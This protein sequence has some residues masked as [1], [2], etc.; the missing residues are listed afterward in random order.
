MRLFGS[1]FTR[2]RLRLSLGHLIIGF[3]ATITVILAF[4]AGYYHG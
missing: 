1:F 4:L 3:A 2:A